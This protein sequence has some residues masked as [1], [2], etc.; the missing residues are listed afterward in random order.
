[1]RGKNQQLFPLN[2]CV[3][4]ICIAFIACGCDFIEGANKR[5]TKQALLFLWTLATKVTRSLFF[6][7]YFFSSVFMFGTS[8]VWR[9]QMIW[10]FFLPFHFQ[11]VQTVALCFENSCI[12]LSHVFGHKAGR[13]LGY[14]TDSKN[15]SFQTFFNMI[16]FHTIKLCTFFYLFEIEHPFHAEDMFIGADRKK[17]TFICLD[18]W[19]IWQWMLRSSNNLVYC[20]GSDWRH[21]RP[22]VMVVIVIVSQLFLH[23]LITWIGASRIEVNAN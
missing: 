12:F 17:K 13:N 7:S 4:L 22:S 5:N 16:A 1:M 15:Q 18:S 8:S 9:E 10:C 11:S 19:H 21:H 2:A 23:L 14:W 6:A 3:T 20:C